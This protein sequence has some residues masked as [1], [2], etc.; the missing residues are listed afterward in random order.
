VTDRRTDGQTWGGHNLRS[1]DSL[2]DV[3]F[4]IF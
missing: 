2:P 4:N 1:I 3:F